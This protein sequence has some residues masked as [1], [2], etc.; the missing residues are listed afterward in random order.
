MEATG[1]AVSLDRVIKRYERNGRAFN[2]VD[3]V[4]LAI[5]P[6]GVFGLLGPNGAG[7]TTS[8]E[9]IAGLRVPTSG[10]VRVMGLD[11]T[12]Y[13]AQ[14][15]QVLAIQPQ[16]AALFE[17]QTV[18][19]LLRVWASFYPDAEDPDHL[20]AELGLTESRNVRTAKLSG[21][22]RQRVLVATALISRP[23]VLVLDEP[24][25]GLD[26]GARQELWT[27]IRARSG[28]GSAVLLS[29]H[30]ME[31]ATALCDQV[32]IMHRGRVVASGA[33]ADLI[34][35][36][37]AERRLAFTVMHGTDLTVLRSHAEVSGLTENHDNGSVRV[38]LT[39]SDTDALLGLVT[40]RLSGRD[41]QI[42]DAGLEGVF[43]RLTGAS[44]EAADE[45]PGKA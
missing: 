6:G 17:Q 41:I 37:A 29:T 26:P 4:D 12:A 14:L 2:A 38:D 23:R 15:R 39:T 21:G 11:P 27:V 1:P 20:I 28:A 25:T 34:R 5:Q 7:K 44:F 30:S 8:M 45:I 36:H 3:G 16:H 35:K 10:T 33:P 43:L 19:E 18:A 31:E 22:Q 24:S 13:R 40:S 9:M 32:A 42:R